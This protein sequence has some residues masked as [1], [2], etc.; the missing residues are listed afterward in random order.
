MPVDYHTVI[1]S[2]C[3]LLVN[4]LP[5]VMI[6]LVRMSGWR[7]IS[8][9]CSITIGDFSWVFFFVSVRRVV[10]CFVGVGLC[11]HQISVCERL[12]GPM[13]RL[14]YDTFPRTVE[15]GTSRLIAISRRP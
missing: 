15:P 3:L 1:V 9:Q 6:K 12:L 2:T 4:M 14:F 7:V 8:G 10:H 5:I 11:R 13:K